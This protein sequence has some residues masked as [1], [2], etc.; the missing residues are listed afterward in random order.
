M[1]KKDCLEK[2]QGAWL[3]QGRSDKVGDD[4][5]ILRTNRKEIILRNGL[6]RSVTQVI[7]DI[8]NCNFMKNDNPF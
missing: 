7:T 2:C 4:R 1:K 8:E 3:L 6:R 5:C